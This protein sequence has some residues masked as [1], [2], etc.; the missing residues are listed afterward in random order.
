MMCVEN[1][2]RFRKGFQ[3]MFYDNLHNSISTWTRRF[4]DIDAEGEEN[5]P[6]QGPCLMFSRHLELVDPLAVMLPLAKRKE[7]YPSFVMAPWALHQYVIANKAL[8]FVG[9][10][11]WQRSKEMKKLSLGNRKAM[12]SNYRSLEQLSL[13]FK[14]EGHIMVFPGGGIIKG[15]EEKFHPRFFKWAAEFQERGESRIAF[16]PVGLYYESD[17]GGR[18]RKA[19]VRYGKPLYYEGNSQDK[20]QLDYFV[21]VCRQEVRKL[22]RL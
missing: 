6:A 18:I 9:A 10:V 11:Q 8:E 3:R 14:H 2:W 22:S 15:E 19:E 5:I 7:I 17:K 20:T 13:D 1:Y 16:S 21:N 12:Q 4:I